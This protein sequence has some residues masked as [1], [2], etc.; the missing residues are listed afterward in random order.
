MY[1]TEVMMPI[2]LA[3]QWIEEKQPECSVI[4]TD[5]Q[6]ALECLESETSSRSYILKH[7]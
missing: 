5:S 7:L 4:C 2:S 1:S 3:L 6:S